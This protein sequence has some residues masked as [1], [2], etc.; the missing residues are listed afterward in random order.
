MIKINHLKN[1]LSVYE[2]LASETRLHILELL[3]KNGRMN[4]GAISQALNLTN[5]NITKHINKLLDAN[6]IKIEL[7]NVPRGV[8]KLC[9]LTEEKIL[10]DFF[11][12]ENFDHSFEFELNAGQF[13]S[14]DITPTCGLANS[15][16]LIGE[17]DEPLYFS[18]PD[19]FSAG[20]LWFRSGW[21]E[22]RFPNPVKNGAHIKELQFSVEISSEAPGSLVHYLSDIQFFLN[23]KYLCTYCCPGEFKDRKGLVSPKN[24]IREFAQ[25]GRLKIISV[26][27]TGSYMDGMFGSET[28]I[29][30]ILKEEAAFFS[31]KI[32][33][34]PDAKN[35]GGV[36]IFGKEFGDYNSGIKLKIF[37]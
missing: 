26:D 19:R 30:D 27:G 2:A 25:Y 31:F 28:T 9:T 16:G 18:S 24:W 37:V 20:I 23:D 17:L 6:L 13:S 7:H 1:G 22:Y 12:D 8:E 35:V 14:C 5:G 34:S 11:P 21:I 33:I 4:L 10:I 15:E 29:D 36:N 32:G 3:H